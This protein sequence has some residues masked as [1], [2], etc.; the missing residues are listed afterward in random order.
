MVGLSMVF[1][2]LAGGWLRRL[3]LDLAVVRAC[4]AAVYLKHAGIIG[5]SS[6]M[7]TLDQ[8]KLRQ[9]AALS[10]TWASSSVRF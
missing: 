4:D 9:Q 1:V 2:F 8:H 10:P 7:S 6:F 3:V 5:R